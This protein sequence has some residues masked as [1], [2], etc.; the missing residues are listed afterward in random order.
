M[1]SSRSIRSLSVAATLLALASSASARTADVPQFMPPSPCGQILTANVDNIF[2][3][4]VD[5]VPL[6][7]APDQAVT[8]TV[9]GDNAPLASGHFNPTM[10]AGPAALVQT[11]FTWTPSAL[12]VGTWH[13]HFLA[14]DQL[15]FTNSCVVT[16]QVPPP[17]FLN[18]CVPSEGGALRC[19]CTNA[20]SPGH[21]CDNSAGTGGAFLLGLGMASLDS[22]TL[23]FVSSG[24]L[25]N[26]LS[27]LL[28]GHGPE[29]AG[30]Q[31]GQGLRC[32]SNNLKRL[33]AHNAS[34]GNVTFPQGLDLPISV[35]SASKGDGIGIGDVRYYM[36]YYR[37]PNVLGGCDASN[38]FNASQTVKV[39]WIP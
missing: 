7:G 31:F 21:G 28:Q 23:H 13:L 12:D 14:V 36:A 30:V 9:T 24:E 22:D 6:N 26:T 25:P 27:I 32:V 37:D 33:Y 20:G 16:I 8:L 11:E 4:E 29:N 5:V 39:T 18:V 10:P 35:Q 38:T 2:A 17:I 15:G 19:P 34:T 3:F 1:F